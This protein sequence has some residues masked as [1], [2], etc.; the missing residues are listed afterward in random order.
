MSIKKVNILSFAGGLVVF[1]VIVG[2]LVSKNDSIRNEI[3]DQAQ[4]FLRVSREALQQLQ[5]VVMKIGKISDELK[6]D[7][8]TNDFEEPPRALLPDS[9]DALWQKV[10]ARNRAFVKTRPA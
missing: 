8:E 2:V 1:S 9:Y 4:G 5:F 7:N 6:T 3:E 10:E